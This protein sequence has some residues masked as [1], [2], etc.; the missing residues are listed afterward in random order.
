MSTD[1]SSDDALLPPSE[2]TDS[3]EVRNADGDEVVGPPD[4]WQGASSESLDDKL[5]AEEPDTA[6][7]GDQNPDQE[8]EVAD[9]Q[10]GRHRGQI[11]GSPEDG[12]SFFSVG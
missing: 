8:P 6:P 7:V 3:D 10:P 1:E 11:S 4:R 12:D 2:A 9:V 5:A